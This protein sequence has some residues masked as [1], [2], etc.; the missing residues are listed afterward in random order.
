M[1]KKI[2]KVGQRVKIIEGAPI[3]GGRTYDRHVGL[4][5]TILDASQ[6]HWENKKHGK[7]SYLVLPEGGT[8]LPYFYPAHA[9]ELVNE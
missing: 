1:A 9:L 2:F 4:I 7:M 5:G 8:N 6:G 3:T